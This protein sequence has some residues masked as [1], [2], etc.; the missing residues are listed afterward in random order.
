[1]CLRAT[2]VPCICLARSATAG[3][4]AHR[5][6]LPPRQPD[7][8]SDTC[9]GR[10]AGVVLPVCVAGLGGGSLPRSAAL[11]ERSGSDAGRMTAWEPT[12]RAKAKS[13]GAPMA[14]R[15]RCAS[16][17]APPRVSAAGRSTRPGRLGS[18][19]GRAVPRGPPVICSTCE[20]RSRRGRPSWC[21]AVAW[22]WRAG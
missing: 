12:P 15:R 9:A 16:T 13:P 8:T 3:A 6:Q 18:R 14:A 22:P 21:T 2:L 19:G 7:G 11:A 5:F 10:R 4:I 20:R 17:P 1:M